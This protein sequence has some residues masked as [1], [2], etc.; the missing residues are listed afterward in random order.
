MSF[1][2][3]T[4]KMAAAA[5]F[6]LLAGALPAQAPTVTPSEARTIAEEAYMELALI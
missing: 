5:A 1:M 6:S 2:K 3:Q 4:L